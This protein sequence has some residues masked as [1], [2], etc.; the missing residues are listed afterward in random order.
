MF[1]RLLATPL[2]VPALLVAAFALTQLREPP[3]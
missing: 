1:R 3:V 2:L